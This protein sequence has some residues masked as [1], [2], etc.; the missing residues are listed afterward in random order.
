MAILY[1]A[2]LSKLAFDPIIFFKSV[3]ATGSTAN[4]PI[5]TLDTLVAGFQKK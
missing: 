3:S 1:F 5:Q 4:A 2:F